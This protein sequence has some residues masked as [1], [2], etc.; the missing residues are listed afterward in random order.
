MSQTP[1]FLALASG[2]M[3]KVSAIARILSINEFLP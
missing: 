3:S 1:D 2:Y